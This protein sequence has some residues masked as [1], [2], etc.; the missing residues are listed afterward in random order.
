MFEGLILYDYL[1]VYMCVHVSVL[2]VY[3]DTT[4]GIV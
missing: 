2:Y 4:V 1:G 3:V